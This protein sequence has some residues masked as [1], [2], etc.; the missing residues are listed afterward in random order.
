MTWGDRITECDC[1]GARVSRE[2]IGRV[3]AYGI[4]TFACDVCRGQEKP[5]GCDCGDS[6]V[7]KPG[8]PRYEQKARDRG[9]RQQDDALRE[10]RGACVVLIAR[11]PGKIDRELFSSQNDAESRAI[12]DV[13]ALLRDGR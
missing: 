10:W 11:E 12:C 8:C 7:C 5:P 4:E 6:G 1:C 9:A 13:A 2:R 3:V